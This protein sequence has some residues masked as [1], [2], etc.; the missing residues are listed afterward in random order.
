MAIEKRRLVIEELRRVKD[1]DRLSQ[2]ELA[3][4]IGVTQPTVSAWLSGDCLPDS[5]SL[6]RIG[7]AFPELYSVTLQA[8]LEP[9]LGDE[10][11]TSGAARERD[12]DPDTIPSSHQPQDVAR[13]PN[14]V[15]DDAA[16]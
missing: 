10:R 2:I 5:A 7:R 12:S 16:A 9:M 11:P 1:R 4:R 15:A 3:D 8:L 14:L 6:G 13:A